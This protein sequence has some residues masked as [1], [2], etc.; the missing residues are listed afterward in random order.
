[1]KKRGILL[2][3]SIFVVCALGAQTFE[4]GVRYL[5][6]AST[7]MGDDDSYLLRFD[8]EDSEGYHGYLQAE[9]DPVSMGYAQGFGL[10]MM[11]RLSKKVDS[12]WLQGEFLW[13]RYSFSF[14][15][16]GKGIDT[17][18]PVLGTVLPAT[19]NGSIC[20]SAEYISIP[21]LFKMRQEISTGLGNDQFQGAYVYMGPAL[22]FLLKQSY[23]YKDGVKDLRDSIQDYVDANPGMSSQRSKYG[24]DYL[25]SHKVDIVVGTG[26]QLKDVFKLG[27]G[28]D[29]FSIDLRADIS[30]LN[31]GRADAGKEFRLVSGMLSL[32][33]K[34]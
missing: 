4:W 9:S 15:Y 19:L 17:D 2:F 5:G 23:E 7:L 6:G 14:D 34:F 12:L 3:F 27:L 10:Y 21:I 25:L 33:Y 32:G 22:S 26:F 1:M 29:T 8:L 18:N 30:I 28:S 13:Q 11:K 16:E 24:A 20:H 31:Q